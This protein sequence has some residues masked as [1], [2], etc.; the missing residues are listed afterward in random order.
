MMLV[1][2]VSC[3]KGTVS[4]CR[5]STQYCAVPKYQ[6]F[7][8]TREIMKNKCPK[9][10]GLCR[11]SG[12]SGNF[13]CGIS[14]IKQ[15]YDAPKSMLDGPQPFLGEVQPILDEPEPV[16]DWAKIFYAMPLDD[17]YS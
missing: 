10:C 4:P 3:R 14:P 13:K 16:F 2:A 15:S 6:S 5:D 9:T 8:G 7:C 11:G 17:Q 12:E 1:A